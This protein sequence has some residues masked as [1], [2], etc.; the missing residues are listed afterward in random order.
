[1][2]TLNIETL[3]NSAVGRP[4][5]CSNGR[6]PR[7]QHGEWFLRGPLPGF[8]LSRAAR[9]PGKS[10]HVALAIWFAAG[11]TDNREVKLTGRLLAKFAVL[12]DAGRRGL[13]QLEQ[14]GL[15]RV[16]RHRGRCPL[17]VIEEAT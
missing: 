15:V 6:P 8:W 14:D 3:R 4:L 11:L 16:Q 10:L 12:P 7:H 9:L 13:R 17:V 2:D 5:P 1:M